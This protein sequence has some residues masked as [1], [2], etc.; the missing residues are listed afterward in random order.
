MLLA[1]R[2]IALSVAAIQLSAQEKP[3]LRITSPESY[4]V[5]HPGDTITV[6][7][8]ASGAEFAAMVIMPADPI[9]WGE[10]RNAP[11]YKFP[12]VIPRHITPGPYGLMADG[13][14]DSRQR[15][16]S[17]RLYIDV[18]R[19]DQPVSIRT[20]PEGPIDSY[21]Q[22][23][24]VLD[25]IGIYRDGSSEYL[26]RSTRTKYISSNPRVV[27]IDGTGVIKSIA[28]GNARITVRIG[29]KV[30]NVPFSVKPRQE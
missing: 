5:V 26:S 24:F 3:T 4:A 18:E 10:M 11:P 2:L 14:T 7:V 16:Y 28:L 30:I 12:V 8:E 17:E 29:A 23:Q 13:I 25:A 20:E 19:S 21:P 27:K 15:V 22:D 1:C 9:P 6:S